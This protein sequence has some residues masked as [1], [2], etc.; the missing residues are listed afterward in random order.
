M[1]FTTAKILEIRAMLRKTK[2]YVKAMTCKVFLIFKPSMGA[3][4]LLAARTEVPLKLGTGAA[5]RWA[6]EF[7]LLP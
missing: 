1:S 5:G 6:G 7:L 4:H 3:S 2:V